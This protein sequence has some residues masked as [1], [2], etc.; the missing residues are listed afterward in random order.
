[1][2]VFSPGDRVDIFN[3]DIRYALLTKVLLHIGGHVEYCVAWYH[4]GERKETWV[5]A[6]ELQPSGE[7]K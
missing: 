2:K 1:M 6:S 7:I 4:N 3:T 5:T